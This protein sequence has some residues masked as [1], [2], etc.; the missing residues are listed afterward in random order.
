[1]ALN[2][3]LNNGPQKTSLSP[4]TRYLRMTLLGNRIFA[5]VIRIGIL[6]RK[7]RDSRHK[8]MEKAKCAF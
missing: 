4:E 1:M 2:G 3:G 5:D 6:I 8:D 7:S